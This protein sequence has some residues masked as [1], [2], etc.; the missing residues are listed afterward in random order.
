MKEYDEELEY[1][2]DLTPYED[3]PVNPYQVTNIP[4]TELKSYQRT[5]AEGPHE[6][7]DGKNHIYM[8]IE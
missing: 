7:F 3:L 6:W 4:L 8:Y 1:D 5:I 2:N